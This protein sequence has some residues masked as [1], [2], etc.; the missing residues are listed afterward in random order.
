VVQGHILEANAADIKGSGA[1]D[2]DGYGAVIVGAS[3]HMGRH[4][5]YV[6]GFV[7]E[8]RDVLEGLPSAFFS[9]SMA[10]HDDPGEA[11]GYIEE[12]VRKTGWRPARVGL[13]SA[14]PCSTRNTAS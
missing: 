7:R 3:I 1:P 8:D 11:E 4:E 6:P 2:P 14:A 12:F 9:V 13:S 10:A 5:D